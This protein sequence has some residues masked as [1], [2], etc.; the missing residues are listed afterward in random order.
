MPAAESPPAAPEQAL[1]DP[2]TPR[3]GAAVR[4]RRWSRRLAALLVLGLIGQGVLVLLFRPTNDRDWNPDQA[5]LANPV[6]TE[7]GDLVVGNVRHA[8]YRAA[9]DFD[10]SWETRRYRLADAESL[11]FIVEP[12]ADWRGPAHT[13]LSFGFRDGSYLA[14]SVEIRKERGESFSPL[15]G[16]LR[17]YELAYV[18]GDE[19]DLIA[20]RAVHR[21][22]DVYLYRMRA[23][24]V[25]VQ[26]LL[27]SM[28]KRTQAIEAS[29]EFYDTLTN[30]CTTNI[31]RHVGEIA[32]G[33]IPWSFKTL[34][35]AY[36]DD[37]A[38]DLG[39]V[40][41]ALPRDTYRGAHRIN[42][43]IDPAAVDDPGFSARIRATAP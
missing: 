15:K 40:D 32:P 12:F 1:P 5:R 2:R 39:L 27:A 7:S 13:F 33:R 37:L 16:L 30:T 26:A 36:A 23:T 29:P 14:I 4:W 8:R 42:D 28:V 41:T 11:W 19:R 9:D 34:L 43:R 17:Q 3:T 10:V 6:I 25:Q 21:K 20:L 22:D 31:V 38:Y 18:F 35:P 24:P